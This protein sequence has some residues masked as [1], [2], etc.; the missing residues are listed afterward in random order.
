M[1]TIDESDVAF[2]LDGL[3]NM[4]RLL[5]MIP[6]EP[7]LHD[8]K[9]LPKARLVMLRRGGIWHPVKKVGSLIEEGQLLGTVSD[10]FGETIE[11]VRSPIRGV[12]LFHVTAPAQK[13]GDA[14][15]WLGEFE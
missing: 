14:P 12:V 7:V 13:A 5:K 4:C 9:I 10:V 1:G 3:T 2:Y 6:G 8:H 15:L 11:E